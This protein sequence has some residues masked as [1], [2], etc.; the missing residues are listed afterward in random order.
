MSDH[1][2][3][4]RTFLTKNLFS[5]VAGFPAGDWLRILWEQHL[6]VSPRY[7]PRALFITLN[8][9]ANTQGR[10][11][12]D[13][14]FGGRLQ[15]V[16]VPPPIFVLGHWRSGTTHLHNLLA[17][18][19]QFAYPTFYQATQPHTF[20]ST[21]E[22]A[23][24]SKLLKSLSPRTRLIDN[25]QA[26]IDSPMEDEVA[27]CILTGLSPI[28]GWLFPRR[29]SHYDRY[30]T[31]RGVPPDEVARW[32]AGVT[33]FMRKLSLRY[34]RPVILKSPPHT[35]RIRLLLELLPEARFIHIHRNPYTVFRSYQRSAR[36]MGQMLWLQRPPAADFDQRV[37]DQYRRM[38]E[39]FFEERGLIPQGRFVELGFEDLERDPMGQLERIYAV[40]NIGGFAAAQPS[41]ARYLESIA[42]YRKSRLPEFE[43]ALQ[44][45]IRGAWGSFFEAWG[46][47]P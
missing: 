45:R 33:C 22:R 35:C 7:V 31:F 6:R 39:V 29:E 32:K 23:R 1:K 37:I 43:S 19:P 47:T 24:G 28:M 26:G 10:R 36:I 20:L 34:A 18:D 13:S 46:Y 44:S 42:G 27:L 17:Q 9:L 21:E 4:F 5:P 40:L 11:R 2:E 41:I 8:S 3:A 38:Y 14:E 12:E 25:M 30:L 15:A 16:E